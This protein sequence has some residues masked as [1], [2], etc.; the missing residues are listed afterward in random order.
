MSH[1]T[2]GIHF[3]W[4]K[5]LLLEGLGVLLIE[6]SNSGTRLEGWPRKLLKQIYHFLRIHYKGN[7]RKETNHETGR[8]HRN[9]QLTIGRFRVA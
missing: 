1:V 2:P 9:W 5:L 4:V 8:K 6:G 7:S 3:S